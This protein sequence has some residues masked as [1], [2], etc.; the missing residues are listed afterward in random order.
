MVALILDAACLRWRSLANSFL[1]LECFTRVLASTIPNWAS[2]EYTQTQYIY[3]FSLIFL[4]FFC[5]SGRQIICSG[6]VL[7]W[8]G[9]FALF[10]MYNRPLS[11][12]HVFWNLVLAFMFTIT[13][14]FIGMQIVYVKQINSSLQLANEGNV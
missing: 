4:L 9:I 7:A 13:M 3:L 1:Y 14:T 6:L 8:H 11:V 2:Y 12:L 10:W 5:D